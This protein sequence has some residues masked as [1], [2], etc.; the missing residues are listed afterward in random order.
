LTAAFWLCLFSIAP[1]ILLGLGK[2]VPYFQAVIWQFVIQM[3]IVYLPL[4]GGSGA[5]ELGLA[6]L[7]VYFVPPSV[8]GIFVLVWRL[9]TYYVSLFFGGL[10]ALGN[11]KP[12]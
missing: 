2:P 8:L 12:H 3:I 10:I 11:L 6:S 9:L 7:F 1:V 4:P 5:A